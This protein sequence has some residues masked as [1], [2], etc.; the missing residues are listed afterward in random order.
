MIKF[1]KLI[2]A[3]EE[4]IECVRKDIELRNAERVKSEAF[5]ITIG[6]M[7]YTERTMEGQPC[8][9]R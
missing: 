3:A 1:P 9:K 2:K 6:N 7:L 5:S 4:K 8:L